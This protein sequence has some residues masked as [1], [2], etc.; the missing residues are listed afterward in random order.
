[1]DDPKM[2]IHAQRPG[3]IPN[4]VVHSDEC[5]PFVADPNSPQAA[6]MRAIE[7][8][9]KETDNPLLH[10][11]EKPFILAALAALPASAQVL[12]K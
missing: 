11:P 1:V 6:R 7:E 2:R 10:S 12:P 5:K 8:E 9:W 4:T 3:A